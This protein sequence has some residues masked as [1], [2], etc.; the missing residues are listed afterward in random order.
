MFKISSSTLA[1]ADALFPTKSVILSGALVEGAIFLGHEDGSVSRID[2]NTPY[3]VN[4]WRGVTTGPVSSLLISTGRL[5]LASENRLSIY[6][7][8]Q[9]PFTFP[10]SSATHDASRIISRPETVLIEDVISV[11][12]FEEELLHNSSGANAALNLYVG[13]IKGDLLQVNSA[14]SSWFLKSSTVLFRGYS[15]S[16]YLLYTIVCTVYLLFLY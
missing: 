2:T 10:S 7:T 16:A 12:A 4:N 8:D 14:K 6:H 11:M 9:P 1:S 15:R 5:I 3:R 13:T